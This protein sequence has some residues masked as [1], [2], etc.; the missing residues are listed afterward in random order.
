MHVGFCSWFTFSF[1]LC[2]FT[3][4]QIIWKRLYNKESNKDVGTL[5]QLQTLI[6]RTNVPLKPFKNVNAAEDFL[7]VFYT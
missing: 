2:T 4:C 5:K 6:D 7:Q 3:F 1:K